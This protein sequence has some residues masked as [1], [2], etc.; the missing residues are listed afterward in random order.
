MSASANTLT[1]IPAG[2]GSGVAARAAAE[3]HM[4]D[5]L[6]R[7]YDLG[8]VI[9]VFAVPLTMAGI[10]EFGEAGFVFCSFVMGVTWA[11]SQLLYG[12]STTR[13]SGAELVCLLAVAL[14]WLQVQP[15][16]GDILGRLSPFAAEKL[17]L[18]GSTEGRLLGHSAWQQIS[19][20]PEAT[21]SGL[22]LLI[23]YVMFFLSLVHRLQTPKDI[24]R[25][26]KLVA[27]SVVLMA[28]IGIAQLFFGN[29][30]FLWLFEHPHRT[31]GWPAKGTFTNQ[32]HFAH[33]LALGLGPL[34]WWWQSGTAKER[35]ARE[36]SSRPRRRS[37][38]SSINRGPRRS[39]R[40]PSSDS[41]SRH[42]P[43]LIAAAAAI[44]VLAGILTIS[45]GG[46]AAL[47][48]A[49][50]VVLTGSVN[51]WKRTLRL[52][53]PLT[54]FVGVALFSFGMTELQKRWNLITEAG[55]VKE[56]AAVRWDLWSAVGRATRD[57]WPAGS[58]VGSHADV[59]PMYLSRQAEV[60]Y[61]HA[62]NGY[63]QVL[64]ETGVPGF[65]L[66]VAAVGLCGWWCLRTWKLGDKHHRLRIAALS[67]GLLASA[68]HS[69]VDFP[70]Y[71]PGCMIPTLVLAACASRCC[72]M[73][74]ATV[75]RFSRYPAI[76]TA[77]AALLLVTALPTGRLFADTF[78]RQQA[79]LPHWNEYRSRMEESA[80]DAEDGN[81]ETLNEGLDDLIRKLEACIAA[82]PR[83]YSAWSMLSPLYLQRFEI[84]LQNSDNRMT[85]REIRDSAEQAGFE[86]SREMREWLQRA[87]GDTTSD[88][89]RAILAARQALLGYP[90]RGEAYVVLA[91]TG[92]LGGVRKHEKRLMI[93]Q[94]VQLRPHEPRVLYAAGLLVE[95]D[96]DSER[97]W[98][99]WQQAAALSDAVAELLIQ[100]FAESLTAA[101]VI[102]RLDPAT[103]GFWQ[104]FRWYEKPGRDDSRLVVAQEF[105]RRY[106][107]AGPDA[108]CEQADTWI[109]SAAM[110]SAAGRAETAIDCLQQA[111][112][113]KPGHR[114]FRRRLAT[115][116]IKSSRLDEARRQLSWIRVR[117]PDN[118]SVVA[119]LESVEVRLRRREQPERAIEH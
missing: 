73:S 20:T 11:V 79:A 66:L 81:L 1:G 110:L 35:I 24:D 14:V 8:L 88:L 109:H 32:N 99:L 82:D 105:A 47:L 90:L 22:V 61:T 83:H 117:S 31:A 21:R 77:V 57:F 86:S 30:K 25:T 111:V 51:R 106:A 54:V 2:H 64:L 37:H 52:V 17:S 119:D 13:F 78:N 94:A 85:L 58:G 29:G 39:L 92:F 100:R 19:M 60:R 116:L 42:Q 9:C 87:F 53:V 6:S 28:T 98:S 102:E 27:L 95:D 76:A 112:R 50:A 45:R 38:T 80:A 40:T 55:S 23:A 74:A 56:I 101:E 84:R 15:L 63:L 114:G 65:L 115:A 91:E 5:A 44:V 3:A 36:R 33:F 113:L 71:I 18:W 59:Y 16:P 107:S 12:R 72:Q 34:V 97:A 10:R 7:L 104:L 49:G 46:I 69:F 41:V 62:E 108:S 75:T 26:M 67:S 89:Y 93:E 4:P 48:I 96:G 103:E 70:W 118:E 43:G 68:L